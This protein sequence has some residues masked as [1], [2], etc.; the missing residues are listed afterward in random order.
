LESTWGA[1]SVWYHSGFC[2][3]RAAQG[4]RARHLPAAPG[5]PEKKKEK[6]KEKK[7]FKKMTPD[8]FNPSQNAIIWLQMP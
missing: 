2:P 6:K 5:T 4:G 8:A 1:L 7:L 3:R